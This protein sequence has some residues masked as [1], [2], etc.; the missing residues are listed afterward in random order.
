LKKYIE[1]CPVCSN[2]IFNKTGMI[3]PEGELLSCNTCTQ[4]LSQCSEDRYFKSMED[5]NVEQGTLANNEKTLKRAYRLHSKRLEKCVN[6]INKKK[7]DLKLLD[8][9][10][11]SGSFLK[12]AKEYGLTNISGV[13]PAEKA[14][15][16]A[17]NNGFHVDIGFLEDIN[18][19]ENSYD[20]VTLF[21]V[22]EHLKEPHSLLN[23]CHR[24]L[25]KNGILLISTGN[26][27]SWTVEMVKEKWDYFD[28]NQ[29]G[30]HISFY[31]INSFKKLAKETHFEIVYF[32][33]ANLSFYKKNDVSIIK[34]RFFKILSE[35]LKP[36]CSKM[37]KGHDI[38]VFLRKK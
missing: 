15:Q 4:L 22:I 13:E 35:I 37:H 21:E 18:L 12:S 9:G 6:L 16:T 31:N 11:S 27:N 29:N 25:D 36:L 14:A 1:K 5:F 24:I 20:I 34:Y 30:G 33:T 10:C 28:I 2:A 8:V 3:L 38:L 26:T 32:S 7:D 23:E 19:K 17:I